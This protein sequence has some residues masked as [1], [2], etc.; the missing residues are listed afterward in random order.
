M[1]D[2]YNIYIIVL[3]F[4]F[5]KTKLLFDPYIN[6][7]L[8]RSNIDGFQL[9]LPIIDFL[10]AEDIWALQKVIPNHP[11]VQVA[12]STM[13]WE[14]C[15]G[16]MTL[17][18]IYSIPILDIG[19]QTGD[20]GYIDFI[21]PDMMPSRIMKGID[22][23]GRAFVCMRFIQSERSS[24]VTLFQ[25]YSSGSLFWVT[26]NTVLRGFEGVTIVGKPLLTLVSEILRRSDRPV[27]S[28]SVESLLTHEI[29]FI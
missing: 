7:K 21:T 25:R 16:Y 2:E 29:S 23:F 8:M 18:R 1:S 22:A 19:T 5:I 11:D 3:L 15:Y 13:P 26:N 27:H 9:M 12:A 17:T 4:L 14:I 20:T 28:Y 24:V 6:R 10:C